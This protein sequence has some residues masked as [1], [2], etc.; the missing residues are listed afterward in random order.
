MTSILIHLFLH[1]VPADILN[2]IAVSEFRENLVSV[3][4]TDKDTFSASEGKWDGVAPALTPEPGWDAVAPA[5][6]ALAPEPKVPPARTRPQ[7]FAQKL[8]STGKS[9]KG[10]LGK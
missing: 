5:L 9:V 6:A 8:R 7:R 3:S 4:S 2:D 10:K 1:D